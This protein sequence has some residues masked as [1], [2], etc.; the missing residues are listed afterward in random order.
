MRHKI[1]K[2]LPGA[3]ALALIV[4]T[5]ATLSGK[6]IIY[7]NP[8]C[9]IP[10]ELP[11]SLGPYQ[12]E[13]LM[14]C[15]NDQC[16]RAFRNSELQSFAQTNA[17]GAASADAAGA[18]ADADAASAAATAAG[19]SA[20]NALPCPSC[21][22]QLATISI[23]EMKM[24]PANTPIFRKEYS[25]DGK[26]PIAVTIVFSG[27]ERRSIH[28]PQ[29]CLAAQGNRITNEQPMKFDLGGGKELTVRILEITQEYG[30]PDGTKFI[31]N[32]IYA[33]W[34]FNPEYETDSH[35]ARFMRMSIDNAM[36]SYRPR[37]G[38]ASISINR[39]PGAPDA[40]KTQ[41]LEF[42]RIF[43]PLVTQVRSDLD[44][45]RDVPVTLEGHSHD[46]N[47]VNRVQNAPAT[48]R[49]IATP[50]AAPDEKPAAK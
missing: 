29:V 22:S 18:G 39:N 26:N 41:L 40:W 10:L 6:R 42:L 5:I 21:G 48:I 19:I 14:F 24:L 8:I 37:W 28:R 23:G 43:Y 4:A 20:L 45:L 12:G 27:L 35:W 17:L 9:E 38:Y 15:Q 1:Q 7:G 49:P 36:R 16:S 46:L 47:T 50:A 31:N 30:N 33:Y 13:E 34:L 25:L 32:G 44:A 11:D 2:A 3:I